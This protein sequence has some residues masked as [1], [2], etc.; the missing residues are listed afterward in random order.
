MRMTI[1]MTM[2]MMMMRDVADDDAGQ[3]V[4]AYALVLHC[5]A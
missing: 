1:V 3:D 5:D 2:M 4:N